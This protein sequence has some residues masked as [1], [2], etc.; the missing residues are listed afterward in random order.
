[1]AEVLDVSLDKLLLGKEAEKVVFI[2][3]DNDKDERLAVWQLLVY[4]WWLL[5]P[6]GGFLLWFIKGLVDIFK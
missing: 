5:F 2:K 1:M 6:I 4:Y 3:A